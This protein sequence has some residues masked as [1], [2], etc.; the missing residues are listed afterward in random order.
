LR[1]EAGVGGVAVAVERRR[2]RK[3]R[4]AAAMAA[5][6]LGFRNGNARHLICAAESVYSSFTSV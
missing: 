1:M 2:R 5:A 6:G 4:A 3:R